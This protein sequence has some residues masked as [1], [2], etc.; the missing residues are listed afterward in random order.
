M[1]INQSIMVTN[2]QECNRNNIEHVFMILYYNVG[3]LL[4]KC[5][6][7][8]IRMTKPISPQLVHSLLQ[9]ITGVLAA[10]ED[11]ISSMLSGGI[12]PTRADHHHGADSHST[13]ILLSC[14]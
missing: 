5:L 3:L 9:L 4:T 12:H 1:S 13:R 2:K 7:L 8:V 6:V 10:S 11:V 14:I